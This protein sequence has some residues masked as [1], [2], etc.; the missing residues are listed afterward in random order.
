MDVDRIIRECQHL[1]FDY[2]TLSLRRTLP[3]YRPAFERFLVSNELLLT[4]PV[5]VYDEE[6]N[7]NSIRAYFCR[8]G[9]IDSCRILIP[10]RTYLIDFVNISSVNRAIIAEPHYFNGQPVLVRKYVSPDRIDLSRATDKEKRLHCSPAERIRR[11]KHL[12]E[13][14]QFGYKIQLILIQRSCAEKE[15]LMAWKRRCETTEDELQQ[16]KKKNQCLKRSIEQNDC[17]RSDL[18]EKY[19]RSVDAEQKRAQLLQDAINFL[20]EYFAFVVR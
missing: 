7:Q 18:I 14:F 8:Y 11:L 3:A 17:L 6:F 13:A 16:W 2:F 20:A 12:L 19:Q 5:T 10:H 9:S 4:L 1:R 15:W